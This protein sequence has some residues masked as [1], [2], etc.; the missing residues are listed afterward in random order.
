MT[1]EIYSFVVKSSGANNIGCDSAIQLNVV[2]AYK[3]SKKLL[4]AFIDADAV[5][6]FR[7]EQGKFIWV[8]N[9][10]KEDLDGEVQ[11]SN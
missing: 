1:L 6:I 11:S 9:V 10:Y 5:E 4:S 7:Y 2:E 8:D 3:H